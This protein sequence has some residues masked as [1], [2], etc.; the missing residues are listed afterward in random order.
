[1]Q[2]NFSIQTNMCRARA[3][4]ITLLLFYSYFQK[5]AFVFDAIHPFSLVIV[6]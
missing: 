2:C 4:S 6:S 3:V 5:F 1:M